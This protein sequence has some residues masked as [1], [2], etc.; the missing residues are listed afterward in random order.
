MKLG[1]FTI[2]AIKMS[3]VFYFRTVVRAK[4][5]ICVAFLT[6]A[7]LLRMLQKFSFLSNRADCDAFILR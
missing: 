2:L 1:N 4:K 6:K 7:A 3:C 5:V